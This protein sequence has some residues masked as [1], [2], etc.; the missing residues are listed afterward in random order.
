M[1]K[2]VTID[3]KKAFNDL[4]IIVCA[5]M[6]LLIHGMVGITPD[7]II[8]AVVTFILIYGMIIVKKQTGNG[9]GSVLVFI[10]SGMPS[11]LIRF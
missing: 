1:K 6:C 8:E 3:Q 4:W 7:G 5:F 11:K 2:E 10:F 9:W